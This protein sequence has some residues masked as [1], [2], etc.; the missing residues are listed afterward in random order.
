MK[1]IK[2]S[3]KSSANFREIDFP[4][5]S[6]NFPINQVCKLD[7]IEL[8][9]Y[10]ITIAPD[11]E[12]NLYQPLI[13]GDYIF[14]YYCLVETLRARVIYEGNSLKEI[15]NWAK[16][17]VDNFR[18]AKQIFVLRPEKLNTAKKNNGP[19]LVK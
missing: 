1:I 12:Y 19:Y 2:L 3:K 13:R 6:I 14:S 9:D 11:N 4:V 16:D 18:N 7:D 8:D 5:E 10:I 17:N 15:V